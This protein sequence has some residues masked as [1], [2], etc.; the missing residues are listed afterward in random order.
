MAEIGDTVGALQEG[1]VMINSVEV[2]TEQHDQPEHDQ[3]DPALALHQQA[4]PM[5]QGAPNTGRAG[6]LS[7]SRE[8]EQRARLRRSASA[9]RSQS[10]RRER[11]SRSRSPTRENREAR[12]TREP[13]DMRDVRDTREPRD[14]DR[15]GS[16]PQRRRNERKE[17]SE[18]CDVLG[19]F[20]ISQRTGRR[21]LEQIFGKFGLKN[22][23]VIVD[24]LSNRSKGYAFLYFENVDAA[25][26]AKK[27]FNNTDID[28]RKVRVDFSM[29]ENAHDPVLTRT[30]NKMPPRDRPFYDRPRFPDDRDRFRDRDRELNRDH[31]DR[32][33]DRVVD[34][35]R[36]R[37]RDHRD[38]G[39]DRVD[40]DRGFDRERE[41]G[42]DRERDR[43]LDRERDR[44]LDRERER[45]RG[46]D[47]RDRPAG[48]R[49]RDRHDRYE[50]FDDRYD[51]RYDRYE[52]YHRY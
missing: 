31:R 27:E 50:R 29:T 15:F 22:V 33:R 6:S 16:P 10:P 32:D 34:R 7:P 44:G 9:S 38:R 39:L 18:P 51:D 46:L 21:E 35:D 25:T 4:I 14:K 49:E 8:R 19:V 24:K 47:R 41:R 42:L 1:S 20:G 3:L 30:R 23:C 26:R 12:D 36:E 37:D 45:E 48:D 40:R 43:G 17:A 11:F 2:M 13:R 52:R 5:V 28:G